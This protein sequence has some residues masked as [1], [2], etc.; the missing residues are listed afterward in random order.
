MFRI[1]SLCSLLAFSLNCF[2]QVISTGG[3]AT[4][5]GPAIGIVPLSA[6]NAPITS[7]PDI[8]L[9]GS[10]PAVGVPLGNTNN[11]D[12]RVSTGASVSNRNAV[13]SEPA[14]SN[15][16]VETG[17]PDDGLTAASNG[18]TAASTQV[19]QSGSVEAYNMG[20]QQFES[21]LPGKSANAPSL[22][23]IARQ[24]RGA[25]HPAA[26]VINNDSI[27]QLNARGVTTGNIPA[28]NS[29]NGNPAANP[30][31]ASVATPANAA[32]EQNGAL[33]ARNEPPP[34]TPQPSEP[35]APAASATASQQRHPADQTAGGASAPAS[36]SAAAPDQ[37]AAA[38][39]PANANNSKN[40]PQTGS[41]LPLLLLIGVIG[42]GGG[43]IYLLRR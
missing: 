25:Q 13:Y 23:E 14:M 11:N 19:A 34:F 37:D 2:G 29:V 30:D 6:A 3:Y 21:G 33:I 27:A 35:P 8:A 22:A 38:N 15:V 1:L 16:T 28:G 5:S 17:I 40:L 32:P 39:P 12:S 31:G 26:R 20:I 36:N 24:V 43:S 10:G 9:P 7:T 42:V 41:S 4:T 18:V